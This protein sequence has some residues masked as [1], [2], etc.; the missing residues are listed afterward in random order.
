[1]TKIYVIRHGETEGNIYGRL[2]GFYDTHLTSRGK[3]Q[4]QALGEKF[5]DIHIDAVYSSSRVRAIQTAQAAVAGKG[6]EVKVYPL[7]S[8]CNLGNWDNDNWGHIDYLS[9]EDVIKYRTDPKIWHAL[10]SEPFDDLCARMVGAVKA[11]AAK[12]D[13]QTIML[14][15]HGHAIR[16]LLSQVLK[17]PREG[18][19][20]LGFGGNTAV[21]LLNVENGVISA[22]YLRDCSHL[23][24]KKDKFGVPL[25]DAGQSKGSGAAINIYCE[26]MDAEKY[27]DFYISCKKAALGDIDEKAALENIKKKSLANRE[28]ILVCK[29]GDKPVGVVELDT[30]KD[31]EHGY[32]WIEFYYIDEAYRNPRSA[33]HPFGHVIQYYRTIN[34]VE[35]RWKTRGLTKDEI[36][37]LESRD[38]YIVSRDENGVTFGYDLYM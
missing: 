16:A 17:T 25:Y 5:K 37:F 4:A 33:M 19:A 38:L 10:D 31:A 27:A 7:I 34:R 11:L 2:S 26:D 32:G 9:H 20:K 29:D 35:L 21:S 28:N 12:H 15:S 13:G 23:E 36:R 8:E 30:R 3:M 18:I 14:V 6:L 1:M 24:G 22:E